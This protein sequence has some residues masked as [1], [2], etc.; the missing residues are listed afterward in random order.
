MTVI[1]AAD[2]FRKA[3]QPQTTV[4]TSQVLDTVFSTTG[5]GSDPL[6]EKQRQKLPVFLKFEFDFWNDFTFYCVLVFSD[7]IPVSVS[8]K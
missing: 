4:P 8:S 3:I 2:F 1:A 5:I 7:I 6:N